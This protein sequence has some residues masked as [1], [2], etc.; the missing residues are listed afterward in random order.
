M[1]KYGGTGRVFFEDKDAM[2]TFIKANK[3]TKFDFDG[4]I[5][6]LWWAIEKTSEERDISKKVGFL[7]RSLV[8]FLIDKK[9]FLRPAALKSFDGEYTRGYIVYITP[10][11]S[12]TDETTGVETKYRKRRR[13]S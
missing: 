1:G 2:W 13:R 3:G 9:E 10:P 11:G 4:T 8:A 12:N 7:M 6:C 5:G